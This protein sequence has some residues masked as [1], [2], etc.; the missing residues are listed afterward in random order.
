MTHDIGV[1][2]NGSGVNVSG[3]GNT[4]TQTADV[5]GAGSFTK[6]G[7][8]TFA[9]AA[10]GATALAG[11]T[12]VASGTLRVEDRTAG[13]DGGFANNASGRTELE[14]ATV[15]F[16]QGATNH[17]TF[18]SNNSVVTFGGGFVNNGTLYLDTIL[19]ADFATDIGDG[20]LDAIVGNGFNVYYNAF[21]AANHYLGG[22]TYDLASGGQLIAYQGAG[23][24][25]P[26]TGVPAP[27][28]FALFCMGVL[29]LG[30]ARR[31]RTA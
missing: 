2:A 13:F 24:P 6:A 9:M 23:E 27:A 19:L 22:L 4:L 21:A 17:G 16:A 15:S 5:A 11:A 26:P 12:T 25:P 30:W 7:T 18:V 28:G 3:S 10:G 29:G 1:S 31:R 20:I 14:G 8:G